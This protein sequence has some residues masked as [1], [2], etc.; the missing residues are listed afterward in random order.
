MKILLML[1]NPFGAAG[2]KEKQ[3]QGSSEGSILESPKEKDMGFMM[4]KI[5]GCLLSC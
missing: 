2:S 1:K 5:Q 4:G 3:L